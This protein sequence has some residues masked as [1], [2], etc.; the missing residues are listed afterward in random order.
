MEHLQEPAA[1]AADGS[2]GIDD[3]GN[4]VANENVR[5]KANGTASSSLPGKKRHF[6][7]RDERKERRRERC[8]DFFEMI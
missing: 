5:R 1:A 4:G 2:A 6:Q 3:A 7:L 8:A